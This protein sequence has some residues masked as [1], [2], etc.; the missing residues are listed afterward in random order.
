MDESP[1]PAANPYAPPV[2]IAQQPQTVRLR[3]KWIELEPGEQEL[4]NVHFRPGSS[5]GLSCLWSDRRVVARTR[6]FVGW[7][8]LAVTRQQVVSVTARPILPVGALIISALILAGGAYAISLGLSVDNPAGWFITALL[9]LGSCAGLMT[10][11]LGRHSLIVEHASGTFRWHMPVIVIGKR[12]ARRCLAEVCDVAARTGVA[13]G[14]PE[15][16][17]VA[18]PPRKPVS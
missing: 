2:A 4:L 7:R 15:S 6:G 16:I 8:T 18:T 10:A 14:V 9:A 12:E 13:T 3:R 11:A 5:G 17:R 1:K